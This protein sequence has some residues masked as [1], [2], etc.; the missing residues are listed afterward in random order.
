MSNVVNF[1]IAITLA[2]HFTNRLRGAEGGVTSF[3]TKLAAL[4]TV[5]AGIGSK[6]MGT[7]GD[8]T[9]KFAEVAQKQGD[10]LSLDIS[11]E[12]MEAVTNKAIA[13]SSKWSKMSTEAFVGAAYDVKSGIASLSDEGVGEMTRYALLTA[14]ATKADAATM[15]KVFA[16]GHGIFRDEFQTDFDFGKKFSATVSASVKRFRTDGADLAAG[17]STLGANS[18]ALGVSLADSLAVLGMSKGSFNSASEGATS[19]KSFLGGAV[20]AQKEL[21]LSFVDT[22]GKLLPMADILDKI[23]KKFGDLNA[24]E[25]GSIKTAF[26]SDEAVK[27]ILALIDKTDGLREAQT[28]LT[29]AQ[30]E[31]L[32]F[33]KKMAQAREYGQAYGKIGNQFSNLSYIIGKQL[34]PAMEWISTKFGNWIAKLV[35]FVGKHESMAQTIATGAVA[36]AGVAVTLGTVGI[37]VAGVSFGLSALGSSF[38][39]LLALSLPVVAVFGA[40]GVAGYALYTQWDKVTAVMGKFGQSIKKA[41]GDLSPYFQRIKAVFAPIVGVAKDVYAWIVKL[42]DIN[43]NSSWIG[44][45]GKDIG[46]GLRNVTEMITISIEGWGKLFAWGKALFSQMTDWIPEGTFTESFSIIGGFLQTSLEGWGKIV[47]VGMAFIRDEIAWNPSALLSSVWDGVKSLFF[48]AM[49]GWI[50]IFSFGWEQIKGILG[51][52][53]MDIIR[54]LW[55]SVTNFLSSSWDKI[56]SIFAKV[57]NLGSKI[58]NSVGGAWNTTK[59]FFGFGEEEEQSKPKNSFGKMAAAPLLATQLLVA[60]P[61]LPKIQDRSF[62]TTEQFQN[63]KIPKIQD[64]SFV[65]TEQF[66][67]AKIPKIQD[68]S[69][70]T[71]AFATATTPPL[72][73][74]LG[75]A[76]KAPIVIPKMPTATTPV[77]NT[78][79]N[80]GANSFTFHIQGEN[81][82]KIAKKVKAMLEAENRDKRQRSIS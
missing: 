60:Q 23:K 36:F 50:G 63:A 77:Q 42:F 57:E 3:T 31:G 44:T 26:G 17:L 30:N 21:G 54:P 32:D 40:I 9:E 64:R 45:F 11:A 29:K 72:D 28:N 38:G 43:P 13:F 33:T 14:K 76:G 59:D 19:Y 34:Y 68:R 27:I 66:Q 79:I 22:K 55:E 80:E 71:T 51:W 2:D 37:A 5:S 52:N 24:T 15:S 65:T 7:F 35:D 75:V 4:S 58:G 1:G 74:A 6:M 61:T 78:T 47:D 53:P 46:K 16:M 69:F 18:K 49:D 70:M 12:G 48:T 8:F 39:G 73:G 62:V 10:L 82:E 67:N 81:P 20:K 41:M 56:A 25:I